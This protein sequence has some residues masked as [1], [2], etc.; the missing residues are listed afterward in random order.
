MSISSMTNVA[1]A[2]R[3][4]V[5]TDEVVPVTTTGIV[6]ATSGTPE[7]RTGVAGAMQIIMTYVPTEILA[8][9]T[10]ISTAIQSVGTSSN[11]N[12][13]QSFMSAWIAF[14]ACFAMTPISVWLLYASKV[15]QAGKRLP[16]G[17]RTWPKWEMFAATLAF[18]AWAFAMPGSPFRSFEGFYSPGV[19]A[20]VLPCTAMLIGL[21][22]PIMHQEL[23]T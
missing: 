18:V 13:E 19:A 5:E 1:M 14:W 3:V 23:K 12:L 9:Y 8:L 17:F 10:S 7:S 20:I 22:A 2:R 4:D 16:I 11:N 15:K 21:A 6:G